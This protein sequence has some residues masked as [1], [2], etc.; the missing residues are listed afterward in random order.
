MG[1]DFVA[2][3][4]DGD[5]LYAAGRE[6]PSRLGLRVDR[7]LP[8]DLRETAGVEALCTAAH[9]DAIANFAARTD[10]DGVEKERPSTGPTP[11]L[12]P[13]MDVNAR[14]PAAMARAARKSGAYFVTIST[15]FVFDGRE[16]PYPESATASVDS[17]SVS[18]YGWTKAV[19]ERDVAEAN[20]FAGVLRI[21]YPYRAEF[22]PKLD[23]ARSLIERRRQGTLPPLFS[24]QSLTP[25]WIPDVG[26]AVDRL[27]E[28]RAPGTF[29]AA[30]P[31]STTPL[32]FATEL[33][34]RIDGHAPSLALGSIEAFLKRPGA[35]PRPVR[36]GLI[37][38][39]LPALGVPLTDW[40]EGLEKVAESR[41]AA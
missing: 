31:T 17:G 19:M 10:V 23:F 6:D 35:T 3:P 4:R 40:R 36:G 16:G 25:T 37:A 22:S 24:D 13:A 7:F 11:A 38:D 27:I 12:S 2:R 5:E 14:A 30:S 21:S 32:E 18:W 28:E 20:P 15:D 8:I 29:H 41:R 39:R 9:P 26:A 33:F 1:S 34:R